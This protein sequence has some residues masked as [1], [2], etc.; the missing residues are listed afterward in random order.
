MWASRVL[1][2]P[3]MDSDGSAIGAVRDLVM[4]PLG[5]GQ[6]PQLKGFV[7]SVDRRQIFVHLLRVDALDSDGI[8]LRGGTVDL[9]RFA[10][11]KG[12]VLVSDDVLGL[13]TSQG[14]IRD[15]SFREEPDGTWR[16][17]NLA[18]VGRG[19]RRRRPMR[20][21]AWN[22]IAP[23]LGID[24]L[25]SEAGR[26]QELHKADAAEELGALPRAQRNE[27]AAALD[28]ES[29]ADVLEEMPEGQQVEICLLY[30]SPSPRDKRQ[31]RMPSS[32]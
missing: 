30:T 11:R 28:A 29:L 14:P 13:A 6:P 31:S 25:A 19:V 18:A 24:P 27:V 32:A 17:M 23:Q 2:R 4:A 8:H 5:Q 26:L 20:T 12:E 21:V 7:A 1:R 15:V 22:E 10:R 9:R 3:L 16:L